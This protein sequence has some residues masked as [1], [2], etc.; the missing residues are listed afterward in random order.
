MASPKITVRTLQRKIPVNVVDLERFA[1][2][3]VRLC[4]KMRRN[5]VTKLARLPEISI[6]LVGN[7]RMSYL[8]RRFLGES[9]PTDVL[10]FQHGEIFISV[11]MAREQARR[12]G[13]PFA[14]EI[15]LYIVH[16]LLHLHGFDDKN[17][18]NARRMRAT[19]EKILAALL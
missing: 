10:T 17:E 18:A 3:A 11:E 13:N 1:N 4:L 16:G 15:R 19:Q 6:L 5:R 12:F 8:H 14:R 2:R 7:R 9:G